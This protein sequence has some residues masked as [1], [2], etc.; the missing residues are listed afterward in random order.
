MEIRYPFVFNKDTCLGTAWYPKREEKISIYLANHADMCKRKS[1]GVE[2][3]VKLICKE[4]TLTLLEE[5]S[6]TYEDRCRDI[7]GHDYAEI[8]MDMI[9]LGNLNNKK[10]N[11]CGC[12]LT[13]DN[14]KDY[15][16]KEWNYICNNCWRDYHNKWMKDYYKR[17]PEYR[18][19]TI[20]RAKKWGKKHIKSCRK[21]TKKTLRK[22]RREILELLGNKCANPFHIDHSA[23]E[24]NPNYI[25]CLQIDHIKGNGRDERKKFTGSYDYYRHIFKALSSGSKDYQLL[26][27]NCNWIKRHKKNENKKRATR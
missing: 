20:E 19:K 23:F 24:K 3:N 1:K 2:D 26:C 10:C 7:D 18:K 14:T 6:H 17:N 16:I 21:S 8:L 5:I 12:S 4:I 27:A 25:H 22:H 9:Y 11:K 15:R 13:K